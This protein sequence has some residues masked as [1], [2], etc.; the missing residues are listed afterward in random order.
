M[1]PTSIVRRAAPIAFAAILVGA[2]GGGGGDDATETTADVATTTS[3]PVTTTSTEATPT[4]TDDALPPPGEPWDLL[5][6]GFDDL[7]T[8]QTAEL[9]ADG[10]AEALGAEI[11]LT[12][13]SG[14]EHLY[15]STQLAQLRGERFPF[16][17]EAA[18]DAEII[19]MLTRQDPAEEGPMSRINDDFLRCTWEITPGD[20]PAE[21]SG[22]YWEPYLELM[23]EIYEEVWQLRSGR[24]TVLI[25]IDFYILDIAELREAGIEEPCV[26]WWEEWSNQI[27]DIAQRHGSTMVSI[28][29]LFNGPD[30]SVDP[31]KLGLIGP[32]EEDASI[33]FY[34][35]NP[36]GATLVAGALL[37]AGFDPIGP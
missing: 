33:P 3:V 32:T 4:T 35:T 28:F 14:F 9:Y 2:C 15:A 19:V 37:E 17:D 26:A 6:L 11:R 8:R 29:D 16:L 30:H 22:D 34:R 27:R 20:A 23:D 13:P 7:L 25:S 21:R 18:A 12:H 31:S 36:A 24:P 1:R 10:A 5:F